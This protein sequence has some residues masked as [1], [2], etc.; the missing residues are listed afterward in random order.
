MR[1]VTGVSVWLNAC[2]LSPCE[3]RSKAAEILANLVSPDRRYSPESSR[4][5]QH[6]LLVLQQRKAGAKSLCCSSNGRSQE[7]QNSPTVM[8]TIAKKRVL[9]RVSYAPP[10][11][12]ISVHCPAKRVV[13]LG[14]P[15]SRV[16]AGLGSVSDSVDVASMRNSPESRFRQNRRR[17][18]TPPSLRMV[19][20]A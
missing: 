5:Y 19:K 12:H 13:S 6:S 4:Y 20:K 3:S 1:A 15:A 17:L 2:C 7:S 9:F 16:S 10:N 14:S 18:K 8:V 11:V